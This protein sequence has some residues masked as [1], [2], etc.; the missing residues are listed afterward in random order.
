MLLLV[1][2]MEVKEVVINQRRFQIASWWTSC[3]CMIDLIRIRVR[4]SRRRFNEVLEVL[5]EVMQEEESHWDRALALKDQSKKKRP[6][7]TKPIPAQTSPTLNQDLKEARMK[8]RLLK[9]QRLQEATV[10]DSIF[11]MLRVVLKKKKAIQLMPSRIKTKHSM[12]ET[13]PS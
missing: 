10:V 8:T 3:T 1:D 2:Q 5:M 11:V 6:K 9:V 7:D 13:A 12:H 4:L